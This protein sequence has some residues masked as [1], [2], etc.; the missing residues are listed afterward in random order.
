MESLASVPLIDRL[1]GRRLVDIGSG[2]GFPGIPIKLVRPTLEVALVESRRMKALFLQRAVQV[3]GLQ[4]TL[5]WRMRVEDLAALPLPGDEGGDDQGR[6]WAG[7]SAEP[8]AV[9]PQ[10]DLVTVRAVA[11]L[12]EVARWVASIVRPGGHLVAFKGSSTDE[13][14]RLW[15]AAPGPWRLASIERGVAQLMTLVVLDRISPS[16]PGNTGD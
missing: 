16:E 9:R 6:A 14:L 12:P 11:P 4:G 15:Q 5:I 1:G 2:G 8:P 13:E 3:L 10:A 7:S